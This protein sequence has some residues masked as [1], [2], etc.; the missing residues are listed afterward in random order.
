MKTKPFLIGI[1]LCGLFSFKMV[2][3]Y[4]AKKNTAEVD[5]Y[6]GVYVFTDSKPVGE[7]DY[8]GTVKVS[9]SLSG[10]YA[11]VRD[12]LIKKA[13]KEYPNANG[14]IF[15]FKDGGTDKA[16]AILIK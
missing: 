5:Q 7:Y 15:N 16:D 1:A 3:D 13:K 10:Q 6:Q 11:S 12:A 14:I 8:L 2:A 9:M 4:V